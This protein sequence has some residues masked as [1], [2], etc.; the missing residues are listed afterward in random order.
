MSELFEST[1][2]KMGNH[3]L[4]KNTNYYAHNSA[5]GVSALK[6]NNSGT[7]NTSC[8]TLSLSANVTGSWNSAL[9]TSALCVNTGNGNTACGTSSLEKNVAGTYNVGVGVKSL[10]D[11][12]SGIN[13]TALGVLSGKGNVEGNNN[14]YI[15]NY[16]STGGGFSFS[17]AIGFQS[18]ITQSHQIVLGTAEDTV[19]IPGTLS[20]NSKKIKTKSMAIDESIQSAHMEILSVG[21]IQDVLCTLK[22]TNEYHADPI[23]YN[24]NFDKLEPFLYINKKTDAIDVG[25]NAGKVNELFPMLVNEKSINYIG[26]INILVNEL[27]WVKAELY[28]LSN[29]NGTLYTESEKT[30]LVINEDAENAEDA[31]AEEPEDVEDVEEE[32]DVEQ[33]EDVED[34]EEEEDVEE[35]EEKDEEKSNIIVNNLV[36]L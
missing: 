34:I 36:E 23:G 24:D 26:L 9:G 6:L 15:G 5:F 27:Q 14:T 10:Y 25:M 3:A 22:S 32:E 8:G 13:N 11:N 30:E 4:E 2:T 1:N 31:E 17:T 20:L 18:K 7:C 21:A 12:V 16:T 33:E 28:K 35:A 29:P 19:F